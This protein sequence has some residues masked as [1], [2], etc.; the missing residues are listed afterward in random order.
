VIIVE[1]EPGIG[2]SRLVAELMTLVQARGLTALIGAGQSIEQHTAYRAWRD[3]FSSYF[4]LDALTNPHQ[5]QRRVQRVVE[6]VAPE[7][8]E[9][10]PLL[11]DLL[12]L[13]LPEYEYARD[14]QQ[15]ALLI[16]QQIGD[17]EGESFA[18][19]NL[20]LLHY[21]LGDHESA[22]NDCQQALGLHQE[23]GDRYLEGYTLTYL[24][25]TLADSG[26]L[27]LATE[28]YQKAIQV[29]RELGEEKL[30]MDDLAGLASVAMREGN[31]SQA[32]RYV[33]EILAWIESNGVEGIEYP[34]QVYLTCY[35][36]LQATSEDHSEALARADT[37][38]LTAHTM[39]QEQAAKIKDEALPC[40]FLEN[41]PFNREIIEAWEGGGCFL[42]IITTE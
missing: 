19:C 8:I 16:S 2:K 18:F 9:R 15:Q 31:N 34:L 10:L 28:A 36:V 22:R 17:R 32:L 30:V 25:H 5:R 35:Q 1:G 4:E 29:R 12:N 33:E 26:E 37:I 7:Q 11:N 42:M 23:I 14:Y 3:I 6:E 38:L 20:A 21:H 41:V 39:L 40:Q 24:A 13:G 27:Q